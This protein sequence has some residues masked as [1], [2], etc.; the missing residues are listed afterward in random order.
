MSIEPVSTEAGSSEFEDDS[1]EAIKQLNAMAE[2]QH[3]TFEQVFQDPANAKLA[4]ATYPRRDPNWHSAATANPTKLL[5]RVRSWC[6]IASCGM[7]SHR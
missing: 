3:R 7:A 2:K 5:R 4:A 1:A 6:L